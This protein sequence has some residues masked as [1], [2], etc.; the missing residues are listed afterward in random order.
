MLRD[1]S[2]TAPK[3]LVASALGVF[4]TLSKAINEANSGEN[5]KAQI[6]DAYEIW[7]VMANSASLKTQG[8]LS[9]YLDWGVSGG[10]L[11]KLKAGLV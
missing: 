3:E 9:Y 1:G 4:E 7:N 5:K 10:R 2:G 8:R 11:H 6:E